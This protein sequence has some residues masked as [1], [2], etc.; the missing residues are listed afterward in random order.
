MLYSPKELASG[1]WFFLLS[2]LGVDQNFL[3]NKHGPC[4]ICGGKDRFRWDNKNGMGTFICNQCGS[5]DGYRL[6]E[7][8]HGWDFY[9]ALEEVKRSEEHTSELQSH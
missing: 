2:S 5:G 1:K 4:P 6:L 7:M 9:K 8:Y 3:K